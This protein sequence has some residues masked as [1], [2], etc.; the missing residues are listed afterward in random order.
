[1][2]NFEKF[3]QPDQP[4]WKPDQLV[5]EVQFSRT[6]VRALFFVWIGSHSSEMR[7]NH[8]LFF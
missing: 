1:M 6:T 8:H 2:T 7:I 4:V 5:H 3:S